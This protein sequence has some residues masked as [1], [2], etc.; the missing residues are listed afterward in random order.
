MK[1]LSQLLTSRNVKTAIF[2]ILSLLYIAGIVCLFIDLTLGVLLWA[3]AM[4]PSLMVFIHQKRNERIL[5][6]EKAE[7]EALKKEKDAEPAK[8]NSG[9]N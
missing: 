2:L 9:E 3:A 1:K 8:D 4:I 5:N 7:E 6:L